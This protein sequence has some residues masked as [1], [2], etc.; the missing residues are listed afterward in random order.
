MLEIFDLDKTL[1]RCNASAAFFRYCMR[2]RIFPKRI[3]LTAIWLYCAFYL[4]RICIEELHRRT[5]DRLIKGRLKEEVLGHVER[6]LDLHLESN[7]CQKVLGYC[8]RAQHL[9]HQVALISTS[10]DYIVEPIGKRLGI[11]TVVASFYATDREGRFTHVEEV[12][13]GQRKSQYASG[14]MKK[15]GIEKDNTCAYTDSI[16][17]LP[18]LKVVGR[19]FAIRPDRKLSSFAR[20]LRFPI[21]Q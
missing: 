11:K 20:R 3:W 2:K 12:V 18:L 15:W 9:G 10:P 21:L 7:L 17:D 19:R 6:F 1:W 8:R 16:E 14:L 5:F 13:T 4:G